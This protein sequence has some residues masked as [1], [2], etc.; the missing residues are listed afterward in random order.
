V[1][2]SLQRLAH[3]HRWHVETQVLKLWQTAGSDG[4]EITPEELRKVGTQ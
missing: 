4:K 3:Q 1:A 2:L